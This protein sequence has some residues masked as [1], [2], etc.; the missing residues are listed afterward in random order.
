ML[1]DGL[2]VTI[3]GIGVVFG[4]LL[5]L[6]ITMSI[7]AKIMVVINKLFPEAVVVTASKV[8]KDTSLDEE[9]AVAIA[10]TK[11]LR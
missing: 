4:F 5:I 8:K 11:A 2:F 3:V 10:A 7:T 6:V 9:I 1:E